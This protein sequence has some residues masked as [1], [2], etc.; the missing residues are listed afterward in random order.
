MCVLIDEA[1]EASRA[2][3]ASGSGAPPLCTDS[4]SSLLF[5]DETSVL[6]ADFCVWAWGASMVALNSAS[7]MRRGS[8]PGITS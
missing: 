3:L 8:C 7:A 5:G 4:C 6:C 1:T 2:S